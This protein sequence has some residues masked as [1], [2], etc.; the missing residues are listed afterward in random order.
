MKNI[1]LNEQQVDITFFVPCFNEEKNIT[2]TLDALIS[3]ISMTSLTYEILVVDDKSQDSTKE[4][5]IDYI[6]RINSKSIFLIE[7][8]MNMGLGRNYI[9]ASF[10]ANGKYYMLVNGDNAEPEQTISALIARVGEADMV[11]PYFGANDS[12][13]IAR[14]YISKAFTLLINLIGGHKIQYYNGPVIHKTFNVMRW[15]PDTHGFA[16]QA[17][18]IVKVLDEKGSFVEVMIMN[19]DRQDGDSKAFTIKNIFSV[20]HSILQIFLRRVRS[21]LFYR[22]I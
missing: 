2:K 13:N 3:S 11:I 5:V 7:N 9:D 4:V 15:S 12:R 17:E 16:Y 1:I 14:F 19:Y 18:I 10:I 6:S 21:F 20:A 8:K 22:N